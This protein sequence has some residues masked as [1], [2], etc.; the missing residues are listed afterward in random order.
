MRKLRTMHLFAGAG[1]G[2]LADLLLGHQPVCAVEIN[3]YCQ[4]VLSARQA[5]GTFPWFPIFADVTKFDGRPWRGAVDVVC[6]GFPCQDISAAGNGDGIDGERSGLWR[7]MARIVGEVRPRYVFVENSPLLV[8]RGLAVVLGD[9]ADMG[10]DA[11][12]FRLS[13]SDLGAPHQRDRCWLVANDRSRRFCGQGE[14]EVE[15]QRRAEAIG[16]SAAPGILAHA[17]SVRELQPQGRERDQRRRAGDCGDANDMAHGHGHGHGLQGMVT[18]SQPR[19]DGRQ[20]GLLGGAGVFPAWP[21]DPADAPESRVGRV[22]NG[23]ANRSHRLKA[24]G[25]GQVPRVVAAAWE[26]LYG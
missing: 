24:I 13:A 18:E 22:V 26:L 15:Q 2:I 17:D 5:D 11:Q 16:A 8:G 4:Q 20:A 1:G 19:N 23:M 12:W 6:G 21:A 3:E 7:E 25:N 14:R 10:Y 9:L